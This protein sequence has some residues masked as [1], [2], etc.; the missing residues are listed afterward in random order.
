[1]PF[2]ALTYKIAAK[3]LDLTLSGGRIE[4]I[5]M[6]NKDEAVISVR[7]KDRTKRGSVLLL[8]SANPS[9]PRVHITSRQCEN[10]LSAFSFLMHLRKHIGGGTI[11]EITAL[12]YER[13]I[14]IGVE[15]ADELGYKKAYR[16][17][18]ELLGRY[19][20]LI[21]TDERGIITDCIRHISFDDFS[22]RAVLPGLE[23]KLPP[24]RR[25][26]FRPEETRKSPTGWLLSAV[27][28]SAII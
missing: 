6:P 20:N 14:R 27:E 18:A 2:D 1:M 17:Y 21:L 25:T 9:R 26:N 24:L 3:E 23:Y 12:P 19:S 13:I 15:A 22:E 4:R 10:P 16:L 7:P 5:G 8:L 11:T 28:I